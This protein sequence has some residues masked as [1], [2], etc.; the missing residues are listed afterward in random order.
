MNTPLDVAKI[1][2]ESWLKTYDSA[3]QPTPSMAWPWLNGR[4]HPSIVLA[5]CEKITAAEADSAAWAKTAE[6]NL[7][8]YERARTEKQ[9]L[10]AEIAANKRSVG[11]G[12][13][14][15]RGVDDGWGGA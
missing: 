15:I 7:R 5:L 11:S 3:P 14:A 1:R 9:A 12:V 4:C 6:E 8:A 10:E 2:A 13:A